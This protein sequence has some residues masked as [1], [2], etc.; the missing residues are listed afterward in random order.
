MLL[1][2]Q[3]QFLIDVAQ[4]LERSIWEDTKR[5]LLFA[6]DKLNFWPN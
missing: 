4:S 6:L 5:S 2:I 3:R 1:H